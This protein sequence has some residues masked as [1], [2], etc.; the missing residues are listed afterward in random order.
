MER[1]AAAVRQSQAEEDHK[2]DR[3]EAQE[4]KAAEQKREEERE[5]RADRQQQS[6]HLFKMAMLKAMGMSFVMPEEPPA[7]RSGPGGSSAGGQ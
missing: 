2:Q 7:D 1:Q 4:R 6:R 3:E 5:A